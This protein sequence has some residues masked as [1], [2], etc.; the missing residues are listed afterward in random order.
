MCTFHGGIWQVIL[1]VMKYSSSSL[2]QQTD[3]L[4]MIESGGG[5]KGAIICFLD[6]KGS[7][8]HLKSAQQLFYDPLHE[9]D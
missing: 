8:K 9:I 2:Q 4:T 3:L 1:L 5:G 7:Y 6:G